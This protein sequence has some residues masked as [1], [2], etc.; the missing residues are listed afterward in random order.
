MLLN[1]ALRN[2][3]EENG[4]TRSTAQSV[5]IVFVQENLQG[6]IIA[7]LNLRVRADIRVVQNNK[8]A[9]RATT[10]R[11]LQAEAGVDSGADLFGSTAAADN[12][13]SAP[14]PKKTKTT[15]VVLI[16]SA[17]VL[18]LVVAAVVAIRKLKTRSDAY[19]V[20][21]TPDD[22]ET[23]TYMELHAGESFSD[24]NLNAPSRR[25]DGFP[26]AVA[27]LETFKGPTNAF[28]LNDPANGEDLAEIRK[29]TDTSLANALN[30]SDV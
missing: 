8:A 14:P 7:E 19:D 17:V 12:P 2:A 23:H 20:S 21:A 16:V 18:A 13:A 28:D 29:R 4:I 24:L 5:K 6:P 9:I 11:Y 1:F 10:V 26:A 27:A 30:V 22:P 15:R 25:D 3:L